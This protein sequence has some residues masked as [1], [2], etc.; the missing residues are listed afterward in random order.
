MEVWDQGDSMAEFWWE[1][2]T[3]VE[4]YFLPMLEGEGKKVGE[5]EG[6]REGEGEEE[7]FWR[8]FFWR[9]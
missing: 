7:A 3:F 8:L 4:G 9:L 5:G 6:S 1:L 2:S